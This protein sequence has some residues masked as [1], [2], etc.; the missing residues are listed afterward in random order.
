[1]RNRIV[2][3]AVLLFCIVAWQNALA[4][5]TPRTKQRIQQRAQQRT[6]S[7]DGIGLRSLGAD[8]GFV[9]PDNVPGTF[10]MG[11]FANLGNLTR[12]IRLVPRIGYWSKSEEFFG[13]EVS[14]R[15]ISFGARGQ[16]M[17]HVSSPKFRPYAGTGLGLHLVR[18][19]VSSVNP[20]MEVSQTESKVGVDFGGGF[21]TPLGQS[22]DFCLD[23]WYT[24]VADVGHVSMR[25]G[26]SFDMGR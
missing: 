17:F 12:D 2:A 26:V 16:Y 15:D 8:L 11:V 1:M 3:L 20:P 4:G 5:P 25:A 21:I 13:D 24:A 18:A 9:D 23:L 7:D 10:G 14:V 22:T 6:Q 19:K